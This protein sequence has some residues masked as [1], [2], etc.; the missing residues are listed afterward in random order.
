M[1]GALALA[2]RAGVSTATVR[3]RIRTV[4][5]RVTDGEGGA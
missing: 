3:D 2:D 1:G 4:Y 5:D